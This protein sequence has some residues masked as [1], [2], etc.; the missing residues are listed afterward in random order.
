MITLPSL[1][2]VS[3]FSLSR[4]SDGKVKKVKK[5]KIPFFTVPTIFRNHFVG[6]KVTSLLSV[7]ER[8]KQL[9][10]VYHM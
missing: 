8:V 4:E 3:L 5:V 10:L 2:L 1:S 6:G 7:K 9:I